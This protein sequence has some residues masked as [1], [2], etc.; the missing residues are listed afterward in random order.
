MVQFL[1]QLAE[2]CTVTAT[3]CGIGYYLLCLWGARSFVRDAAAPLPDFTPPVSILKPLRGTDPEIY[4]SFKSHCL[5]DYPEY[6]II[7]GISD[8]NDAAMPLVEQLMREFPQRDIKLIY[9]SQTLGTNIKVSNLIQMLAVARHEHIVVNDSDIRVPSDYLRRVFAH[10]ESPDV[11]MVTCM[12]RGQAGRSMGSRLEGVGI[13]TE[14]HAGVLAARQLEGEIR[15][16][17]GSTLGFSRTSLKAMGGLEP[18]VDYLA[19]D[20]ELGKRISGAGFRV[21][22]SDVVVDHYLPEYSFSEFFEHQ[23][24]WARSTRHSR[25]WG[26]AGLLLTFAVPWALLTVLAAWGAPWAW[27]LLA[28]TL[29]LRVAMALEVGI[30]V[31]QDAQLRRDWW[32][33]PYRD[34]V[35]LVVWLG[36][37]TGQ[38]VAWRGHEFVLRDG[39]LHLVG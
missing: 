7:F 28:G 26:Y 39:K 9:C 35:A 32:L 15:F 8:P 17:L 23:L 14:F 29:I 33:I 6:E 16:A 27:A 38:T 37:Y 4:E 24:R 10:M 13:S 31:L 25:P 2:I 30:R 20:Y 36:S 5:Q 11:G 19:D 22:L 34:L 21:V 1:I 3:G 18:L 12:Y